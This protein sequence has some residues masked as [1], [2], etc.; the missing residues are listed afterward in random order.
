V[1]VV[2]KFTIE[3]KIRRIVEEDNSIII[4]CD[5]PRAL[6][7]VL[8]YTFGLPTWALHIWVGGVTM[9]KENYNRGGVSHLFKDIPI[10]KMSEHNL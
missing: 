9:A 2:M 8:R 1:S 4:H 7:E 5:R 6:G 3:I 10:I